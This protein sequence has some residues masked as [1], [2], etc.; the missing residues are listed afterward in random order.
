MVGA[1]LFRFFTF[2]KKS[3]VKQL[4]YKYLIK[5]SIRQQT[6]TNALFR[7]QSFKNRIPFLSQHTFVL[8]K[9]KHPL[10]RRLNDRNNK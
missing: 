10:Q 2:L 4:V 6:I 9:S 8:V 5:I 7:I 3:I 1:A